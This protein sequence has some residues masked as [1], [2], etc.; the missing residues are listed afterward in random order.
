[1]CSCTT[2]ASRSESRASGTSLRGSGS[3]STCRLVRR[4][5]RRRASF[6]HPEMLSRTVS[7]AAGATVLDGDKIVKSLIDNLNGAPGTSDRGPR[8]ELLRRP[9]MVVSVEYDERTPSSVLFFAGPEVLVRV[10]IEVDLYVPDAPVDAVAEI[11]HQLYTWAHPD[12]MVVVPHRSAVA[13]AVREWF[14]PV[15]PDL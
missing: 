14:E 12:V 13:V 6:R 7:V 10:D 5:R 3:S 8:A 11:V 15:A 4:V 9:A 2:P 1:M